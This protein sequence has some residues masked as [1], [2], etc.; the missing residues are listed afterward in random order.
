M[1]EETITLELTTMANGG[2]ALGRH[3][4]RTIFVPYTIPG[5]I[6]EAR[7]IREKGRVAFA[8]GVKFIDA[9]ADRVFPQCPHFGPSR[10]GRCQWQHIDYQ[11]QLLLK[12][13][14]LADQLSRI[15]GFDDADVLPVIPA[16]EQWAYNYHMTFEFDENGIPGFLSSDG[17]SICPMEECHILHSDLLELFNTLDMDFTGLQRLQLHIGSDGQ[18]MLTLYVDDEE[19]A[20]QLDTDMTTSIN[21]ILPDNTPVNLIGDSHIR[22]KIGGHR[23]RVTAGSYFRAN[24]AQLDAL[25]SLVIKLLDVNEE[26]SVLDLYAGVGL[27]SA[28]LAQEV[29]LV[30]LVESYP[31]AATDADENLADFDNVDVIEGTVEAVLAA[32]DENMKY[33]AVI[34][35]PPPTGLSTDAV[36]LLAEIAIPRIVYISSDPATLARDAKRLTQKGY[37]LGKI[38]PIDLSPQTYYV[39][40]IALLEK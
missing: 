12:Q 34:V 5:E 21:M 36:D 16:P 10:C 24:I 27:F 29:G 35:D 33:D 4:E 38:Q 6:I 18:H 17:K 39:D 9:S 22:H 26:S 7:I 1:T 32:V 23:L 3:D 28:Y 11:A 40:S 31:P 14:V 2:S 25:A 20:P 8:E 15:G 19:N 13:D 30:T 37:S